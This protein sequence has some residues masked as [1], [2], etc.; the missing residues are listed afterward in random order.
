MVFTRDMNKQTRKAL[1]TDLGARIHNAD[2]STELIMISTDKDDLASQG[3]SE[4]WK[5]ATTMAGRRILAKFAIGTPVPMKDVSAV[6]QQGYDA[7]VAANK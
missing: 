3:L 2:T 4:T 5:G 1:L 7:M 6:V